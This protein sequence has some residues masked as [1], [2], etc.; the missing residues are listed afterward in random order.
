MAPSSSVV[1][2]GVE[3]V[4]VTKTFP[5]AVRALQKVS[6]SAIPCDYPLPAEVISGEIGLN[7]VNVEVTPPGGSPTTIPYDE[8]C[9]QGGWKYDNVSAPSAIVICPATCASVKAQNGAQLKVLL[10]CGTVVK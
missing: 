8:T 3:L 4:S 9:A 1:R 7:K 10:G 5:P 6:G 2:D